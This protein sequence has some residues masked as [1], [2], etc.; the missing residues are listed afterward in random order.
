MTEAQFY[1]WMFKVLHQYRLP[2]KSIFID[3]GDT[4]DVGVSL[5][6]QRTS[7]LFIDKDGTRLKQYKEWFEN[8]REA[9]TRPSFKKP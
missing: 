6:Y 1:L 8:V 4:P 5:Y 2:L 3:R 7:F 9:A